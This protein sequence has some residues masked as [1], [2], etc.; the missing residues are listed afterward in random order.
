MSTPEETFRFNDERSE[1]AFNL[2]ANMAPKIEE[3]L[4]ADKDSICSQFNHDLVTEIN[5]PQ[6]RGDITGI[7]PLSI[8]ALI[9]HMNLAQEGLTLQD[10]TRE[11][12]QNFYLGRINHA[13]PD[14][15][16]SLDKK[17]EVLDLMMDEAC[18]RFE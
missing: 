12:A 13:L 8:F 7:D 9:L 1:T 15:T 10:K 2:A 14:T 11:E 17:K 18:P 16:V 6:F 4:G 3:I 5:K